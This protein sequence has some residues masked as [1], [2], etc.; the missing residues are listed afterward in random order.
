MAGAVKIS[1]ELTTPIKE[2]VHYRLL[3][4]TGKNKGISY[5]LSG[6]RAIMGRGDEADVQVL[7]PKSSREHAELKKVGQKYVVTDLGSQNGIVINDLKV[8]QHQLIDGDKIIIGQTVFKYSILENKPESELVEVDDDDDEYEDDED[9][10]SSSKPS[11]KKKNKE[12][13]KKSK[14]RLWILL[15]V[16]GLLW[17]VLDESGT[18]T[19]KKS[20]ATMDPEDITSTLNSVYRDQKK[21]EDKDTREKVKTFIHRG[22]REYREGNYFRA[23]EQLNLCLILAPNHGYCSFLLSKSKQQFDNMIN[24]H[25][26]KAKVD[27]DALKYKAAL[28]EYCAVVRLLGEYKKAGKKDVRLE[29]AEKNIEYVEKKL[30]MDAGEYKCF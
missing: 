26:D 1:K 18:P 15:A 14:K 4:L 24:D 23:I 19:K 20:K 6:K 17:M 22:Q 27:V 25:F 9:E 21:I 13:E 30:G 3:C 5:Y 8:T 10:E 28:V 11:K 16:L 2:G 7:D 12:K 29:D